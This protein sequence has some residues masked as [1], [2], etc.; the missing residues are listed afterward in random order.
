MAL[1]QWFPFRRKPSLNVPI[2]HVLRKDSQLHGRLVFSGGLSVEGVVEGELQPQGPNSAIV[3]GKGARVVTSE[4][5]A[6]ILLIHGQVQAQQ[7]QAK[8][9]VLT[10]TAKVTGSID[11]DAVEIHQGARFGGQVVTRGVVPAAVPTSA[12]EPPSRTS[13]AAVAKERLEGLTGRKPS[14]VAEVG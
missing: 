9:V 4:L 12:P 10:A 6:D 13:T 3:V 1:S 11:A 7:I 5:K 14:V 8:Q 2:D